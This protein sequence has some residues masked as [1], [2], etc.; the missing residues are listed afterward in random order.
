MRKRIT[1]DNL[2]NVVQLDDRRR[3]WTFDE[4][5]RYVAEETARRLGIDVDAL[6]ELM[7]LHGW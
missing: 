1:N 4:L 5:R 2:A 7:K 6:E 3:D